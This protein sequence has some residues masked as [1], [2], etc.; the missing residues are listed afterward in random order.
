[1]TLINLGYSPKEKYKWKQLPLDFQELEYNGK[2]V[3]K[4]HEGLWKLICVIKDMKGKGW[5]N[6]F[7]IDG[8]RRAGK[9]TLAFTLAYLLNPNLTINNFVAGLEEAPDKIEKAK[10]EDV[11]IFDEGSLVAGSKDKMTSQSKQLHRIID[12]IGQKRLTL[13]FVMPSIL[14]IS[15]EIIVDHSMFF[16]RVGVHGKTLTRGLFKVY[17]NKKMKKFYD[18]SK[19]DFKLGKKVKHSFNGKFVDFHLPFEEEYFKL[20]RE[21]MLEAIN[22]KANKKKVLNESQYKTQLMMNF[23]DNCPEIPNVTISRGFGMSKQEFYRRKKQ[24]ITPGL[25]K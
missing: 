5:D 1:M 24:H 8:R 12:V 17:K 20:K 23:K 9:S 13:I 2:L 11:L 14:N 15:R 4:V 10:D 25:E 6:I 19:K 22:P 3:I 21:S 7:N 18:D 16:I